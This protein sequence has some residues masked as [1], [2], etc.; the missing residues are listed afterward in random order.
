MAA[1]FRAPDAA[2]RDPVGA[3]LSLVSWPAVAAA[4]FLSGSLL[5]GF[6]LLLRDTSASA[7]P[8]AAATAPPATASTPT[9]ARTN[10]DALPPPQE[11]P[12]VDRPRHWHPEAVLQDAPPPPAAEPP[13]R[14]PVAARVPDPPPAADSC[15]TT[16]AEAAPT[17]C[18]VDHRHGTSLDFVDDPAAAAEK[19]L[20]E[21]K[22]LFILH[23]A[24]NFEDD[25][26]T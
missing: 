4:A 1:P 17:A 20:K 13:E 7:P 21:N 10:A 18:T 22:L 19:A 14:D 5:A 6:L 9:P 25:K 8:T 23:V 26:F 2:A 11:A 3:A 12:P 16:P 15:R 24:G